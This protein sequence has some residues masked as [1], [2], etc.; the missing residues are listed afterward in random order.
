MELSYDKESFFDRVYRRG[1]SYSSQNNAKYALV[2]FENFCLER[3]GRSMNEVLNDIK[4]TTMDV[5]K[6]LDS[7]VGYMDSNGTAAG[8]IGT[9]MTWVRNFM[10]Y[11]DIEISEYK[12]RQKVSMPKRLVLKDGDLSHAQASRILQV[13][14]HKVRMLC[15]LELTSL[16]R[17]NELLQLRVRDFDFDSNPVMIRVPANLAKNRVEG[18][19][20]TTNECISMVKEHI[21]RNHLGPDDYLFG[22]TAKSKYR[23]TIMEHEFL[24]NIRKY[25]DLCKK[26]EGSERHK[27][28]VYS[29][30]K[31]GY[32]RADKKFGKNYADGLKGDKNSE[33]HR[34]P[35][36]EKKAMYLE[37]ETE[38]TIFN[39]DVLRKKLTEETGKRI[40]DLEHQVA[41]LTASMKQTAPFMIPGP[42]G[43]IEAELAKLNLIDDR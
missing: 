38:L 26:I 31:F 5:Y 10:V 9:Y 7:F 43:E 8:T 13:L 3:F 1:R 16:R 30:K 41:M 19:T 23:V 40:S 14:P 18:E 29:F 2:K 6:T 33:Y 17:P 20:F 15:I 4:L 11:Y 22:S 25:T 28:H 12:F 35:L 32:T 24:Y 39:V 37:L 27:I 21:R 36:E 42:S 34:L